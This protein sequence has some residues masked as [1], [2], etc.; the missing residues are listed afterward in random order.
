MGSSGKHKGHYCKHCLSKFTSHERFCSHYKM[1]CYNV[2]GTLKLM[3][4]EDHN[5]I[6]INQNVMKN[7]HH[8]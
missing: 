5:I 6:D 1:G 3:P 4:K 7:Y 8:L 2:V